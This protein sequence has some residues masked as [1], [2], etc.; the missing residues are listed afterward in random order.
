MMLEQV[1]RQAIAF[2][3]SIWIARQYGPAGM[4]TLSFGLSLCAVF[5]VVATLGLNRIVVREMADPGRTHAPRELVDTTVALR[6]MAGLVVAIAA[7]A[8]A[9]LVDPGSTPIVAVLSLSL[10][11]MPFDAIDLYFQ[12]KLRSSAVARARTVAF[13]ISSAWKAHLLMG[14]A[15]LGWLATAFVVDY[16][17]AAAALVFAIWRDGVG[18]RIGM[19]NVWLA[20]RL[21]AESWPEMIAGASAL[22]FMRID[23]VM[24]QAM[25]GPS[26]VGIMAVSSRLSEAWY[27][28]PAAIVSSTYPA[29][30]ALRH[31]DPLAA[32]H[33]QVRLYRHLLVMSVVAGVVVTLVASQIVE[34]FYGPQFTG[35]ASVLVIQIW[36]GVFMCF[37]IASGTWLMSL[38]LARFN[39]Y[40]TACGAL[41]NVMLNL[42]LI[43]PYGPVGAAW[44]TLAAFFVA[45]VMVDFVIPPMR[46]IGRHKLRA[47][48]IG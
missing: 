37:G 20:K 28:I 19:P 45:Y 41:V 48:G 32:E 17:F 18:L 5:G 40:R 2:G 23:Q 12:S 13:V 38:K 27:F 9:A 39:L 47:L 43:P 34:L 46:V 10:L 44:A 8:T 25:R 30:V 7:T 6:L 14:H 16:A 33:R 3:F 21:L 31:S 29:I 11:F 26:D 15:S 4:G 35:A 42:V 1:S 36:C 22:V 24:L